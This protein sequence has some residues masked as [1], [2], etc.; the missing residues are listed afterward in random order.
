MTGF[1]PPISQIAGF[2]YDDENERMIDIPTALDPVNV[3]PST[4]GCRDECRTGV[5]TTGHAR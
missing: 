4:P 2:G 3:T 1:L 5:G